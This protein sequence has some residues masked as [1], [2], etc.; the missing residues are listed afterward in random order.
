MQ[1]KSYH[2]LTPSPSD[3]DWG[4]YLNVVGFAEIKPGTVYPPEGHPNGYY[5]TWE[6]GR[7][8]NEYQIIYITDGYGTFETMDN[9][10]AIT[11]GTIITLHPDVWHRYRPDR[12]TGW[13]EYYVGFQETFVKQH[14][15]SRYGHYLKKPVVY[16]GFQE[17]ILD[18]YNKL[19][20][21]VEEEKIGYQQVCSGLLIYLTGNLVSIIRNKEFGGKIIKQKILKARLHIKGNI[22]NDIDMEKLAGELN[23]SYSYFRNM[24]KK[25]TGISPSQY[26]LI[27]KL[28]KAREMIVSSNKSIKEISNELNFHSI[29]YFSQIF[30]QKMGIRPSKL[31]K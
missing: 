1:S 11:P 16:I 15:M 29:Y 31:R 12:K 26:H 9:K 3:K 25:Y 10:Y 23:L 13:K 14:V 2:Y 28:Q 22:S 21:E 27:L 20:E 18:I 8:L 5:F 7:V 4:L 17:K 6:N 24:Y 19:I 30:K